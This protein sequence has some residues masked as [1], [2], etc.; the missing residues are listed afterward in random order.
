MRRRR[1]GRRRTGGRYRAMALRRIHR[2]TIRVNAA[3]QQD[4]FGNA[5]FV[6]Q[7]GS[8]DG[9]NTWPIRDSYQAIYDEFKISKVIDKFRF[10]TSADRLNTTTERDVIHWSC[11]DPDCR[12]REF[13]NEASFR[14][15][16]AA[17]WKL[18][19]PYDVFT[20]TMYPKYLESPNSTTG[21]RKVDNPWRDISQFTTIVPRTVTSV[22]GI[23]HLFIGP[24]REAPGQADQYTIEIE[25]TFII[26]FRGVRQGQGYKT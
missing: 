5:S 19:K 13:T 24:G 11:Y 25:R 15:H 22:N 2:A 4:D 3:V 8:T 21:I 14:Q 7:P 18:M 17:K 23:Q 9:I 20:S 1:Y 10:K 26:L 6:T 16:A 12:G